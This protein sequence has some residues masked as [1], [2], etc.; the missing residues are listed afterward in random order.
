MRR[1]DIWRV[2]AGRFAEH[3]D[4]LDTLDIFIWIGTVPPPSPPA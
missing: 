2:E 3:W 4:E 1:I